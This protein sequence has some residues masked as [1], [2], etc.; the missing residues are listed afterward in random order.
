[1]ANINP[2]GWG[3][4]WI[5]FLLQAGINQA[6]IDIWYVHAYSWPANVPPIAA[7]PF[8]DLAG[9]T[10]RWK[11]LGLKV[12]VGL[13]ECGWWSTTSNSPVSGLGTFPEMTPALQAQYLTT[14]LQRADI[15]ALPVVIVYCLADNGGEQFGLTVWDNWPTGPLVPKPSFA[16]VQALWV[17]A[18]PP[19]TND[20][21]A[22]QAALTHISNR[23]AAMRTQVNNINAWLTANPHAAGHAEVSELAGW[24][25][26]EVSIDA[27]F[28]K[29]A[30]T[31]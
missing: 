24:M 26:N 9:A 25:V 31:P 29:N 16:A 28:L 15:Q 12:P 6:L 17:P 30:P 19:V 4:Q 3:D 5:G 23:E 13:S 7:N 8:L 11:A 10:A 21:A 2:G 1:M 27:T 18:A 20:K 22:Y 14:F